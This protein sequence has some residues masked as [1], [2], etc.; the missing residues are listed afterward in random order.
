ML[1]TFGSLGFILI[2]FYFF[3]PVSARFPSAYFCDEVPWEHSPAGH[4]IPTRDGEDDPTSAVFPAGC[5]SVFPPSPLFL[6]LQCSVSVGCK[7]KPQHRAWLC[8]SLLALG[9]SMRTPGPSRSCCSLPACSRRDGRAGAAGKGK[10]SAALR[11][12]GVIAGQG[13]KEQSQSQAP[14][15]VSCGGWW[16]KKIDHKT[17]TNKK[18][19]FLFLAVKKSP[20]F[21]EDLGE[22][23]VCGVWPQPPWTSAWSLGL[24]SAH[25]KKRNPHKTPDLNASAVAGTGPR[26]WAQLLC[27]CACFRCSWNDMKIHKPFPALETQLGQAAHDL[28]MICGFLHPLAFVRQGISPEV[29]PEPGDHARAFV[30][31]WSKV[32]WLRSSLGIIPHFQHLSVLQ[33]RREVW[34]LGV[35]L[36]TKSVTATLCETNDQWNL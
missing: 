5:A 8:H 15:S 16:Q 1:Y 17:T 12:R 24:L 6:V 21:S 36:N 4:R 20:V 30:K 25:F 2:S 32:H 11:V 22:S 23:S 19:P 14:V 3:S 7:P 35:T 33:D 26:L 13:E 28:H 29:L 9:S 27:H 31:C 34:R 18:P 10:G